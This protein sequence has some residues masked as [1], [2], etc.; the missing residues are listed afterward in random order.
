MCTITVRIEGVSFNDGLQ[1]KGEAASV[2]DNIVYNEFDEAQ[3]TIHFEGS[4]ENVDI[5]GLTFGDAYFH[6]GYEITLNNEGTLVIVFDVIK[7]FIV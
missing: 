4:L 6:P 1:Y 3:G 2:C 7:T 5:S